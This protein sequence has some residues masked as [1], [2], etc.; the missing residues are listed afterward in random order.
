MLPPSVRLSKVPLLLHCLLHA[1]LLL[2]TRYGSALQTDT[3]KKEVMSL[4]FR[5]VRDRSQGF[6][7]FHLDVNA[8]FLTAILMKM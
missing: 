7:S 4:T 2:V 5:H 3:S 8:N 1:G 6:D